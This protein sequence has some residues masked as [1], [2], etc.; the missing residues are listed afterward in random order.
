MGGNSQVMSTNELKELAS[1]KSVVQFDAL[2]SKLTISRPLEDIIDDK[3]RNVLLVACI[4]GNAF[5]VQHLVNS[6]GFERPDSFEDDE[7]MVCI[8]FVIKEYATYR[9]AF[10]GGLLT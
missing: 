5:L 8:L 3:Q 7:G 2:K 4:V 1:A 10:V 9:S 6:C